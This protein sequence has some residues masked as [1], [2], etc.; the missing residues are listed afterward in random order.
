MGSSVGFRNCRF[1]VIIPK[2]VDKK[3]IFKIAMG[4][5]S[6]ETVNKVIELVKELSMYKTI[7]QIKQVYKNIKPIDLESIE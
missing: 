2:V 4:H 7:E 6:G 3:G 1:E 5:E